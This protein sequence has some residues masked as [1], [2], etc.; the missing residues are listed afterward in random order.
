MARELVCSVLPREFFFFF[1][2]FFF[3]FFFKDL[4]ND[5]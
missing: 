3:N 1:F 4:E 2:F 5:P